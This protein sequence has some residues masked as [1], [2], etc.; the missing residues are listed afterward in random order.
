MADNCII[1]KFEPSERE[2]FIKKQF[3]MKASEQKPKVEES[4][5]Q[6]FDYDFD[7]LKP[8]EFVNKII[9]EGIMTKPSVQIANNGFPVNLIYSQNKILE[10]NVDVLQE[11]QRS[12]HDLLVYN[13]QHNRRKEETGVSNKAIE[14]NQKLLKE[15]V[16]PLYSMVEGLKVSMEK[17][18]GEMKFVN[19]QEDYLKKVNHATDLNYK[20]KDMLNKH[21][22]FKDG[23]TK[24][25]QKMEAVGGTKDD[26]LVKAIDG[27]KSS[28]VNLNGEVA[29]MENNFNAN[30]KQI[31]E[32]NEKKNLQ[33]KIFGSKIGDKNVNAGGNG[34]AGFKG[35]A[36]SE[37]GDSPL[38]YKDIKDEAL[39]I[40]LRKDQI[41]GE[42]EAS[43]VVIPK[44]KPQ[45]IPKHINFSYSLDGDT[46]VS[47]NK[48]THGKKT[49]QNDEMLM[50]NSTNFA[51]KD[52]QNV[53]L[54]NME[55]RR[56]TNKGYANNIQTVKERPIHL[57]DINKFKEV[58]NV[59]DKM[60]EIA[61][62]VKDKKNQDQTLNTNAST[63]PSSAKYYKAIGLNLKDKE[64]SLSPENR[65]LEIIKEVDNTPNEGIK[66]A[67]R[68]LTK[69]IE[70]SRKGMSAIE[71]TPKTQKDK[72]LLEEII[73]KLCLE[74]MIGGDK[75]EPLG[76]RKP[77]DGD[78][79]FPFRYKENQ[80][81]SITENLFKDYIRNAFR[82][83]QKT[84]Q[85]PQTMKVEINEDN[86]YMH[87][88]GINND[89]I[90]KHINEL[91]AKYMSQIKVGPNEDS[92]VII[93]PKQHIDIENVC[94]WE[95]EGNKQV[96][97]VSH[98]SGYTNPF[99]DPNNDNQQIL[100]HIP[101]PYLINFEDY[102]IS[103]SSS[104]MT[105]SYSESV[106]NEK[107][108]AKPVDESLSEG[109]IPPSDNYNS[110]YT[111]TPRNISHIPKPS[112]NHSV[113]H[114]DD[115]DSSS[116]SINVNNKIVNI[117]NNDFLKTLNLYD[118]EEHKLFQKEF[119]GKLSNR[120]HV[121]TNTQMSYRMDHQQQPSSSNRPNNVY[122]SFGNNNIFSS[123]RNGHNSNQQQEDPQ[124][125]SIRNQINERLGLGINTISEN[126]SESYI[127]IEKKDERVYKTDES[128]FD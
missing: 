50:N 43:R 42:L 66:K 117:N 87:K 72:N 34:F 45:K 107:P 74:K 120:D 49:R 70:V 21:Q 121:L 11:T 37:P 89:D 122:V 53:F 3:F 102:D 60:G 126:N 57:A 77:K 114:S 33:Q 94:S 88:E 79:L 44:V 115:D 75:L 47:I 108:K 7:K 83:K 24:M 52:S 27:I 91:F 127:T 65:K 82:N 97:E 64:K 56:D 111:V 5:K 2:K 69:D 4:K 40:M 59:A 128:S 123:G 6:P 32:E 106:K 62:K 58:E 90:L 101:Y 46:D 81:R 110:S 98:R 22:E 103:E 95:I 54:N 9:D 8:D 25:Q 71:I 12:L 20:V 76:P 10:R 125:N 68:E 61:K 35:I 92:K 99:E 55:N 73:L 78:P 109:Q 41:L 86:Q 100:N 119:T 39:D 112:N 96:E 118:S 13:L 105:D 51:K 48:S 36:A 15:L 85:V 18:M 29:K 113:S 38:N 31:L 28:I 30:F 19:N 23:T 63:E 116:I 26:Y 124:I 93:Q 17:V 80:L 67:Q 84:Q 1:T 14:D 104:Y 16:A